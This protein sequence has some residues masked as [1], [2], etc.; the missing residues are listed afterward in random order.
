MIRARTRALILFSQII[1]TVISFIK[2]S[3]QWL[4]HTI[5]YIIKADRFTLQRLELERRDKLEEQ[6]EEARK[7]RQSIFRRGDAVFNIL[8]KYLD[9]RTVEA[10]GGFIKEKIRLIL[11]NR[12]HTEILKNEEE[13]LKSLKEYNSLTGVMI[14]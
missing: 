8:A 13:I 4:S 10:F 14:I 7:L 1:K 6:L 9:P 11:E 3:G 2:R 5:I 12:Q